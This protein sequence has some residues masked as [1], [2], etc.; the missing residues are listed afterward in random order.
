MAMVKAFAYGSGPAE[1]AGL[2]EYHGISYLG[3]A[4]SDEGVELRKAGVSMPVMVMNPDITSADV[5]IQYN[6]EPEIYSFSSLER[7][8]EAASKHGLYNYP[9]HIKIDTGMHR[10]GFMP[11]EIDKMASKIKSLS[12]IKIMSSSG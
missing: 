11:D 6:L 4:Y 3:V 7:F 5:I 10:L 12:C 8:A 9:V 1:I 2:L